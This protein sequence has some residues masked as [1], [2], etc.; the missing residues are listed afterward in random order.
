VEQFLEEVT[1]ETLRLADLA[2]RRSGRAHARGQI[3]R[4][5]LRVPRVRATVKKGY[6]FFGAPQ[7]DLIRISDYIWRNS[8]CYEVMSQALYFYQGKGLSHGEVSKIRT[9][10]ARC[11]C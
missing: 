11:D 5:R 1:K 4:L 2:R 8:D 9:W 10:V 6:S 3:Y 7:R